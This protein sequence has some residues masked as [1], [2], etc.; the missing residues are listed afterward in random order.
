M[1]QGREDGNVALIISA[2]GALCGQE[3]ITVFQRQYQLSR[4]DGVRNLST[5]AE[6]ELCRALISGDSFHIIHCVKLIE[7]LRGSRHLGTAADAYGDAPSRGALEQA[8]ASPAEGQDGHV[9]SVVG[10][11]RGA[12]WP[13]A[14]R[15]VSKKSGS[16]ARA[17]RVRQEAGSASSRARED[18]PAQLLQSR[19]DEVAKAFWEAEVHSAWQRRD[20]A[21]M[22]WALQL[23]E[24][25]GASE[26]KLAPARQAARQLAQAELANA[27]QTGDPAVF[28]RAV[29]MAEEL[30]VAAEQVAEARLVAAE[31]A[32]DP[33][34][35]AQ[36]IVHAAG[37]GVPP[38]RIEQARELA[39]LLRQAEERA[40]ARAR[41]GGAGNAANEPGPVRYS[42]LS[43]EST[44]PSTAWT[45]QSRTESVFGRGSNT[46]SYSSGSSTAVNPAVSI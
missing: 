29:R 28:A 1:V 23:A 39:D 31:C 42:G 9:D 30:G 6:D 8:P 13:V 11:C 5:F 43:W 25:A 20:V 3:A 22:S 16:G 14:K 44:R 4:E 26:E 36:E 40:L 18:P 2:L 38:A 41:G 10:P 32:R 7:A 19:C 33:H 46:E 34:L 12:A 27:L 17:A 37:A 45:R 24:E 21:E 15:R 35:I